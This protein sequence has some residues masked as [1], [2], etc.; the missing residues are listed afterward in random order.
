MISDE[1]SALCE[2]DRRGPR[3]REYWRNIEVRVSGRTPLR[4]QMQFTIDNMQ[5]ELYCAIGRMSAPSP[6]IS[7]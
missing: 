3:Y 7:A 5:A 2:P 4:C 6:R 1:N